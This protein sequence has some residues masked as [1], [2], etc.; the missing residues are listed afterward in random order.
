MAVIAEERINTDKLNLDEKEE[1]PLDKIFK[2]PRMTKEFILKHCKQHKLYQTPHLNDVLYLHY[3]G[4]SR[5]ENLEEY[6]GLRCLW[7]ENNGIDKISG[8]DNQQDLRSLFL[9]YNLIKKI[10]NL[11]N[12]PNLNMLNLSHNQLRRI[13]N[14]DN[15]VKL[16]TLNLGNNYIESVEELEHLIKLPEISVLDLSNN[17]IEDPLI[18]QIFSQMENLRVLCL[19]GNPV[20]RK[21]PAYR[22]T[23]TLACVQLRYLDDRPIFP[24]DRA[25]AEAWE[26]GGIAEEQAERQ[27][28]ID[29][30]NQR[31]MDSVDALIRMRDERR[32]QRLHQQD[33]GMGA[34]VNDSESERN[35]ITEEA[36]VNNVADGD[37]TSVDGDELT[38]DYAKACEESEQQSDNEEYEEAQEQPDNFMENRETTEDYSEYT[39]NIFDFE[40]KKK[41]KVLVEEIDLSSS[42]ST[43]T[44]E[45]SRTSTGSNNLTIND[46][47]TS[48]KNADALR[49]AAE[50]FMQATEAT[51]RAN[52]KS[53][54]ETFSKSSLTATDDK[55]LIEEVTSGAPQVDLHIVDQYVAKHEDIEIDAD[56]ANETSLQTLFELDQSL[57]QELQEKQVIVNDQIICEEETI[58]V[59]KG[60][61]P[62]NLEE[63]KHEV[64][65]DANKIIEETEALSTIKETTLKL[66]SNNAVEETE[67]IV[68]VNVTEFEGDVTNSRKVNDAEV[69][70][71]KLDENQVPE[72]VKETVTAKKDD[73]IQINQ[74][75]KTEEKVASDTNENERILDESEKEVKVAEYEDH[76]VEQN[77]AV[78]VQFVNDLTI[79]TEVEPVDELCKEIERI[80]EVELQKE[81]KATELGNDQTV[82]KEVEPIKEVDVVKTESQ[83]QINQTEKTEEPYASDSNDNKRI[84][85]IDLDEVVKGS[86]SE[87]DITKC[88][89]VQETEVAIIK[90]EENGAL[91]NDQTIDEEVEPIK[92]DQIN[93]LEETSEQV[94]N[95][96]NENTIILEVKLN[97]TIVE[98]KDAPIDKTIDSEENKTTNTNVDNTEDVV[99]KLERTKQTRWKKLE[100]ITE[101]ITIDENYQTQINQET[102]EQVA[103]DLNEDKRKGRDETEVCL[104]DTSVVGFQEEKLHKESVATVLKE[105][106]NVKS[107]HRDMETQT[108]EI[109]ESQNQASHDS[110]IRQNAMLSES[111]EAEPT[112]TQ[113]DSGV[114]VSFGTETERTQNKGVSTDFIRD[115]VTNV[116]DELIKYTQNIEASSE[117]DSDISVDKG[118]TYRK[119]N[120]NS[121]SIDA[122]ESAEVTEVFERSK[123]TTRTITV[124]EEEYDI[125]DIREL[126]TW[127]INTRASNTIVPM[128]Y[129]RPRNEDE[130]AIDAE[131]AMQFKTNY[132][133]YIDE[134]DKEVGGDAYKAPSVIECRKDTAEPI[135]EA[136]N[137]TGDLN[138][139]EDLKTYTEKYNKQYQEV[140]ETFIENY[141]KCNEHEEFKY[142][143]CSDWAKRFDKSNN[144]EGTS[145]QFTEYE[146][147]M[148]ILVELYNR[149]TELINQ[150]REIDVAPKDDVIQTEPEAIIEDLPIVKN[151]I[152]C[153]LEM[154]L[155]KENE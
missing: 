108:T 56:S 17:H 109:S 137:I 95:E 68:T 134:C 19:N 59:K 153:T 40:P 34:S 33:S 96:S 144:A 14:L 25:C 60:E 121:C 118:P 12:C 87:E 124:G 106:V 22:K 76:N 122:G 27:R 98:I 89:N 135:I 28:W 138:F 20:I 13:E 126:L 41:R 39:E 112:L 125:N 85:D 16:Q 91:V 143:D 79:G 42:G 18:V 32:L 5:I 71:V 141:N 54:I 142:S 136:A 113:I 66:E 152:T 55:V 149:D 7:L 101:L 52:I 107:S 86:G 119:L 120:R 77:E 116:F 103:N 131:S 97:K 23:L 84:F 139:T 24:R 133:D 93:Q 74:L 81:V 100:S 80:L 83:T 129:Q 38:Y 128:P 9:H 53:A 35:S 75:E 49:Q 132:N 69:V 67:T 70:I 21:I 51:N 61:T 36:A 130:I 3:K 111:I 62:T 1:S 48:T 73:Q 114:S 115:N 99:V 2:T 105:T 43:E 63:T 82:G 127:Q 4:F 8:L 150:N 146:N 6:T 50:N 102:K 151:D 10:E 47:T 45:I 31:I 110:D 154:Q 26:R 72:W 155:A 58:A 147:D 44:T 30:E 29:R 15:N 37:D 92:K 46:E 90:L 64:V 57:S 94:E 88:Q 78:I 104:P 145:T 117:S 65:S 123:S 148:D 140:M 11:A